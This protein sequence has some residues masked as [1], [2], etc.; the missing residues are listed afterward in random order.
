M[1]MTP[2][3]LALMM[4]FSSMTGSAFMLARPV[5]L[6][7][8]AALI[9]AG[10]EVTTQRFPN[11]DAAVVD[12]YT[13]TVYTEDG[14]Y[15]TV[16]DIAIKALTEKGRRDSQTHSFRFNSSYGTAYVIRA[17]IIKPNG[18][19]IAVDVERQS[20]AMVDPS[21][22]G[23]N[24]YDPAQ[25][26]IQLTIPGLEINDMVRYIA[27]RSIDK[28][29]VP[30]TFSDYNVCEFSVP[31]C[32]H[33][34][35]IFGPTNLALVHTV[36][37]DPIEDT[38]TFTSSPMGLSNRY[39]WTFSDVPQFFPEPAM[40]S[41]HTVVQRLLVST[42]PDWE[43]V[44]RWYYNLCKAP[45]AATTPAM[46]NTVF[47]L[48][49]DATTDEEKLDAIFRFASQEIRYMGITTEEVAP[50]Y[51]PRAVNITFENKYGVCRDKVALHVALLRIAGFRA[52]PVLMYVG[53]Q[54]D[55]EVPQPFFNHAIT[56]VVTDDGTYILMDPTDETTRDM[57]PTY[58]DNMSYLVAM[59]EGD[60]LRTS[61]VS[62]AEENM[63]YVVTEATLDAAG[64]LTAE[65]SFQFDGIND[66][67]YRSFMARATP[68]E[69]RRFFER[70]TKRIL[71]GATLHTI[72][73]QPEN[74]QDMS[75]PLTARI[76]YS[77]ENVLVLGE[78]SVMLP[79]LWFG[80]NVG[81]V[82]FIIDNTGLEERRFPFQTQYA[83][84]VQETVSLTL[85]DAVGAPI[86]LPTFSTI[87]TP[88]ITW[89][90]DVTYADATLAG[91]SLFQL[92][93][94]EFSPDEY[95]DLRDALK[96][97]EYDTRKRAI[98]S[99]GAAVEDNVP[100]APHVA[101]VIE[102]PPD[103]YHRAIDVTVDVHCPQSWTITRDI[104]TDILT[105]KGRRDEAELKISFTPV[106]ESVEIHHAWVIQQDGSTN[107][108]AP[109]EINI[110]DSASVAA[111]PRY[112]ETKLFVANLPN[113]VVGSTLNISYSYTVTNKPFF[114]TLA[115]FRGSNPIAART[116]TVRV[117]K[118][119]SFAWHDTP[120]GEVPYTVQT[121]TTTRA[122]T[123]HATNMPP[124]TLEAHLPPWWAL[125]PGVLISSGDWE[126]YAQML[127][128]YFS[129][130][131]SDQTAA[132]QRARELTAA[133]EDVEEKVRAIR[134]FIEI[135]IRRA[136]PA[137]T[138]VPLWSLSPADTTLSEGYGHAA[139]KAILYATMLD[140]IGLS[141]TFV[142]GSSGNR[143]PTIDD[144]QQG[145]PQRSFFSYVLVRVTLGDKDVYLNDT[146]QYAAL[147]STPHDGRA[148][149]ELPTGDII[150]IEAHDDFATRTLTEY[151][152]NIDDDGHAQI[153]QT[154]VFYGMGYAREKR[155]YDEMTAE[156]RRRHHLE[157]VAEIARGAVQ[158]GP[159]ET[160][161]TGYPG[162]E[163]LSV[164]LENYAVRD[165]K[166]LYFT[167]PETYE[168]ILRLDA[169][170]RISPFYIADPRREE[171]ITHLH[172]PAS[173][174]QI[175]MH[176][177]SAYHILPH[178]A[179]RIVF[180]PLLDPDDPTRITCD[181]K[182]EIVPAII[183]ADEYQTLR[184][185]NTE[186]GHP[187]MS[188]V[189]LILSD[190]QP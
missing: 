14:L 70:V 44:S 28:A 160:D 17:E 104:V 19:I 16:S 56:C 77:A 100:V 138:E 58:L 51:E 114:N 52:Y 83:C 184:T 24:I 120:G 30:E 60:T 90:G 31:I 133:H 177:Q 50:G 74:M 55:E 40:P 157:M 125:A 53:P 96:T 1:K 67:A 97:S 118:E 21:Q 108:L 144:P 37:K 18:T 170:R 121:N 23:M 154:R 99:R 89:E 68:I 32:A 6:L 87:A 13:R 94:V 29:R 39:T 111:A 147:G 35:E 110:M 105:F 45:L 11:A 187:N 72:E 62:P 119:M 91:T 159:L 139:D 106:E 10:A 185:I 36:I 141:P 88:T 27:H 113:V 4:V 92:H 136:G 132:R 149:L 102:D 84:G 162:T 107:T 25:M 9:A 186:V 176:P 66:N 126:T 164:I 181:M 163:T 178:E 43:S 174:A 81:M 146:T 7:D 172:L 171:Y 156:D 48:I 101:D 124:V 54:M 42:I 175:E 73:L 38:H 161:F 22:M 41:A 115:Y 152:I 49:A 103:V 137:F 148:G 116:L 57:M 179:G 26:V 33:T 98:F 168:N 155:R 134:D 167:L 79:S 12:Y 182:I 189:L 166:Y 135:N 129:A 86:T 15:T 65:T 47:E 173:V 128:A 20:R 140:E 127:Y 93:T 82:N 75:V 112:P 5:T 8:D 85:I 143:I 122:Y 59:P 151:T 145:T 117:P 78:T 63:V 180:T 46:S 76:T 190:T 130:H 80:A 71:P 169:A 2:Y 153:T 3:I 95:L 150:T 69:R 131:M 188:M 109:E 142:V 61:P 64:T 34:I 158:D 123:W 165:G 183:P